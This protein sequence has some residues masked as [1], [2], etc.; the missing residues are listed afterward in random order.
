MRDDGLLRRFSDLRWTPA[1]RTPDLEVCI[2]ADE[3]NVDLGE[4][5][6]NVGTMLERITEALAL[7]MPELGVPAGRWLRRHRAAG[8]LGRSGVVT[9][10]LDLDAAM[11]P[12]DLLVRAAEAVS[13]A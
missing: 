3:Q 7:P 2:S 11:R 6:I 13:W 1:P 9:M 5:A 12:E 8:P 4:V 10:P